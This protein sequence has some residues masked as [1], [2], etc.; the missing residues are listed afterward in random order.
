MGRCSIAEGLR[1][2]AKQSYSSLFQDLV[3]VKKDLVRA[4]NAYTDLDDSIAEGSEEAWRVFKEQVGVIAPDLDL[5][6]LDPDKV[7]IN[8]AIVSPPQPVSES[9]L[10]TRGQRII[11]SFPRPDDAPSSS[12]AP[13]TSPPSPMDVSLPDSGGAL[14]TLPG[15]GGDVLPN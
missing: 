14:T 9:E 7:V 12:K 13:E 15:S 3:E 8:G 2:K 5:S 6:P 4:Q 1:E 10:K 11:E